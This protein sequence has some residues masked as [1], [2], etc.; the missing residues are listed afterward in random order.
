MCWNSENNNSKKM[1]HCVPPEYL[2]DAIENMSVFKKHPVLDLFEK[3]YSPDRFKRC[4][5]R[6]GNVSNIFNNQ[7][8]VKK[9]T[10]RALPCISKEMET[11]YYFPVQALCYHNPDLMKLERLRK[12][13][14]ATELRYCFALLSPPSLQGYM[15]KRVGRIARKKTWSK[16]DKIQIVVDHIQG[17]HVD[18]EH[19]FKIAIFC[20]Q[21]GLLY[22]R[23]LDV[24]KTLASE[25]WVKT[26]WCGS[27]YTDFTV[28]ADVIAM[29]LT[30]RQSVA[31]IR[32]ILSLCNPSTDMW[33]RAIKLERW[34]V[35]DLISKEQMKHLIETLESFKRCDIGVLH[36]LIKRE[37]HQQGILGIYK[38]VDFNY[39]NNES[40]D[41]PS[42]DYS[43]PQTTDL[44]IQD[45]QALEKLASTW[46]HS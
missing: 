38:Y 21:H 32:P 45:L 44:F 20:A 46:S 34:D 30:K 25:T 9:R 10:L 15:T 12:R 26:Y 35:F 40:L 29:A 39:G 3:R 41:R 43:C 27:Y 23:L 24:F 2:L 14:K 42:S 13:Q 7:K 36:Q 22:D 19:Y 1:L 31:F 28:L 5:L 11:I 4:N 18:E 33:C 8:L 16:K 37:I 17:R 6:L